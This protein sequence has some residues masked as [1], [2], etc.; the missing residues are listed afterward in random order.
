MIPY[1]VIQGYSTILERLSGQA[2]VEL[3][4]LMR[5][6]STEPLK[7]QREAFMDLLPTFGDQY[8]GASS[9]VSAQ[10]FTE[11]QDLNEVK[12]PKAPETLD[13][14]DVGSWHALVGFGSSDRV[15]EQGGMALMYSLMAGGLVKRLTESSADTIVGNAAIQGGMRAQRVPRPGCCAFCGM[16]ASRFAEYRSV[17]SG[18]Q[19]VGRGVPVGQGRGKGSKGLGL[20]LRPRGSRALGEDFHDFCRCRI[21]A[22]TE[23]N[24]VQLQRNADRYYDSYR[25]SADKVN[26]GL[27]LEHTT[28]KESDGTLHNAYRWVDAGGRERSSKQTTGD[29]LSAM[30]SDLGIK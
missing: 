23:K 28:T 24:Y 26:S 12:K 11:L 20:G 9:L 17:E 2:L 15:M 4:R 30:R 19:V 13:S 22:V 25:D 16:L 29:I 8:V 18:S 5:S 27:K 6:V 10:F 3:D 14:L 1:S 21:V 7:V